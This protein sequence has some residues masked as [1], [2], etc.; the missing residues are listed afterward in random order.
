MRPNPLIATLTAMVN[1]SFYC[2]VD[3]LIE[4]TPRED[5]GSLR[6]EPQIGFGKGFDGLIQTCAKN[7]KKRVLRKRH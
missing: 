4:I 2:D 5:A 7:R 1:S 6:E 3:V